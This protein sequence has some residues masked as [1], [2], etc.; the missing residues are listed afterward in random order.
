MAPTIISRVTVAAVPPAAGGAALDL[1]SLADVKEELRI[2]DRDDDRWLQKV[3]TRASTLVQRYCDRVFQ[4]QT[5][6]EKFYARRDPYPWQLPSG[7]FPLQLSAWPLN[8]PPSPAATAPPLM[9]ALSASAGGS[10]AAATYYA[11]ISYVTPAGETAASLEASLAVAADNLLTVAPPIADTAAIA[12]GWN[13]YIG[14]GSFAEI[15]QN[16]APISLDA[17]FTMDAGGLIAP[18][19]GTPPPNYILAVEND[20]LDPQPLA[21]GIDFLSDYNQ[22]APD[23]SLGQLTRL[24]LV[25]GEPR[26]WPG[27]PITIVYQAGY[28]SLPPDLSDAAL[29]L[30]KA[31]WFARTRDPRLRSENVAGAYDATWWFAAGPGSEGDLPPDI[32]AML[33]RYRVPVIG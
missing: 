3:I 13:C 7:F 19:L 32:K 26:R 9:P 15:K 14:A 10:L 23:F 8:S 16:A 11:R 22:A 5:Y 28:A 33:D 27:L 24:F 12:T 4:P 31:R 30:V 29:Q 25:D 17:S 21:E 6:V 1:V 18:P 2:D 20:P